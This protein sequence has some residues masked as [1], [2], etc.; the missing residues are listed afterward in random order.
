MLI[1]ND[2]RWTINDEGLVEFTPDVPDSALE[3]FNEASDEVVRIGA[4][5]EELFDDFR[6]Q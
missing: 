3:T 2:G 6:R 4:H 5:Q 1:E